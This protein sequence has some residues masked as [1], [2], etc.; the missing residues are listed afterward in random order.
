MEEFNGQ[1]IKEKREKLGLSLRKLATLADVSPSYLSRIEN[2]IKTTPNK[3]TLDRILTVL[4]DA[5]EESTNKAVMED[6]MGLYNMRPAKT[7]LDNLLQE[8]IKILRGCNK[9]K[10]MSIE[11]TSTIFELI[12]NIVIASNERE[13]NNE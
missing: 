3:H 6:L 2:N 7:E 9:R 11:E 5:E 1:D 8:L 12:K 10:T 4:T 13:K